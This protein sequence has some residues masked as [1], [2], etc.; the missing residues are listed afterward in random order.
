M[1]SILSILSSWIITLTVKMKL[2]R[3]G[4]KEKH[5]DMLVRSSDPAVRVHV[6]AHYLERKPNGGQHQNDLFI[7]PGFTAHAD[8]VLSDLVWA[9]KPNIPSG[10]RI[11][12]MDLPLHNKNICNFDGKF[13]D[14]EDIKNYVWTF[15]EALGMGQNGVPLSLCGY[16][17]GGNP[18][19]R[20]L[21]EHPEKINKV[22]LIAPAFPET[23][24]SNFIE[25]GTKDPR[26][27]HCW[28]SLE[29]VRHFGTAVAGCHKGHMMMYNAI[30]SGMVRQ[31]SDVY[32]KHE[33]NFFANYASA[34]GMLEKEST[35]TTTPETSSSSG[36][37]NP[38]DPALLGKIRNPVLLLTGDRDACIS[39]HKCQTLIAEA[40]GGDSCTVC[41][42]A[43]TGHY[44]GPS[45][46]PPD[47]NIFY[48]SAPA[49]AKFLFR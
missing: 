22:V 45:D 37:S 43:D 38:L 35:T 12:V 32:G 5:V 15:I 47:S 23:R 2:F 34:M 29:E 28:Q 46:G 18:C 39:S 25:L 8:V 14:F 31:R 26:K 7:I 13:P 33:G 6:R 49:I 17:L 36:S 48:E 1:G 24:D 42:L 40:I 20:V 27:I 44:G 11:V 30:L 19:L 9:L 10:W 4:L 3:S 16:S 21:H 41:E